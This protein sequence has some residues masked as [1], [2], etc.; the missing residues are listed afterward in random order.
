MAEM[1]T[2]NHMQ[3]QKEHRIQERPN[4]LLHNSF[5]CAKG[6]GTGT[7]LGDSGGP[8]VCPKENGVDYMQVSVYGNTFLNTISIYAILIDL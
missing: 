8:L 7:C 6:D 2:V 5:I 3:C 1:S 4:F